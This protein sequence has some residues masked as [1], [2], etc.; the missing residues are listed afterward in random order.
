MPTN[1]QRLKSILRKLESVN[2]YY[3]DAHLWPKAH[4]NFKSK[5]GNVHENDAHLWPKTHINFNLKDGNVYVND[6]HLWPKTHLKSKLWEKAWKVP[7]VLCRS[8]SALPVVRKLQMHKV[9]GTFPR[10]SLWDYCSTVSFRSKVRS[11][12]IFKKI[13][14]VLSNEN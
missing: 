13:L 3:N 11:G 10:K 4:I 14:K 6:A 7:G 2:V 8:T 9:G 12:N 1:G 5:S